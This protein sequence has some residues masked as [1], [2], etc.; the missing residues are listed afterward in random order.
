MQSSKHN[1]SLKTL[2][3]RPFAPRGHRERALRRSGIVRIAGVDEAGRGSLAGPVVAGAVILR[4]GA[5]L[6]DLADS[7]LLTPRQ[8]EALVP[9]ILQSA[10]AWGIGAVAPAGI[11]RWNIRRASF[12]AMRLALA[13][14]DPPPEHVLVDGFR[15]PGL[16]GAQTG[17][18]H[19]DRLCRSIAAASILAK[20][21]RDRRMARYHLLYPRFG[22]DRNQ[23]YPT[24]Q[25]LEALRR[26]GPCPI[27]RRTYAPVRLSIEGPGRLDF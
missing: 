9:L 21:A 5:R 17:V 11:D 6:P 24:R 1:R 2:S 18:V 10:L 19:G 4:P 16:K 22:F 25:H 13:R 20:V 12:R 26:D 15:I 23:G 8:R 14:L 27:H 7:K 3:S